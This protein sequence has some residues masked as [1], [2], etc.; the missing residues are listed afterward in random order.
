MA[1]K[2]V[3]AETIGTDGAG[4]EGAAASNFIRAIVEEDL[5]AG[6]RTEVITRFP[7]EPNGYP[8]IGHAKSICLN[9]GL[10][11][12]FGGTCHLRFDDTNPETEDIEYVEAIKRDVRW[13]GFDWKDKE[14][15]ASDYF[16][17]L[18]DW[19]VQLIRDGK[20]YVDDL[21]EDEIRA[22]R[23]TVTEPGRESP[24]R[25][26]SVAEN[27]DL[28]ERMRQGTFPD[29]SRVLRARIDMA[30][31][32]MKMRDP[33]M[34][35]IRHATHYRRGD[36]WC[37]YPMYDWAHGQSDAIE[38]ITHSICTLEFENNR[39]LYDWFLD[40][41]GVA[42]RP[43]QYE[44]ARLN[45]DY[46]I[47][48]KR[49]LL[50]LVEEGYVEGWDDPRMP[51]ISGM[52][53]RG[54]TPEAIRAF[55]ERIGVTKVDSRVDIGIF[56][57]AL[58]DDL[59]Y[60][61]PRVM[62]VLRPLKV[63]LTN[64]PDAQTEWLEAPYW[65]HDVPKEGARKVPFSRVLYIERDDFMERPPRRYHRLAPGREVRL[66]YGYFI[67]CREVVK[68]ASGEVVEL[69]CTYDPATR[70]GDAPDG[71][72]VKGTIHWVSAAHALPA[73]VRLYDRLFRRPNPDE[74]EEDFKAYLNPESVVVLKDSRIEP[75]VQ[76]D[77]PGTRY[78][79]ERQGYFWPDPEASAPGALVFNRI[80]TLRDSW[81]KIAGADAREATPAQ[82]AKPSAKAEAP[83]ATAKPS[84]DDILADLRAASAEQAQRFTRYADD[85]GLTLE[86]ARILAADPALSTFFED[87][88]AAQDDPKGVANW[89]VNELLGALDDRR[90]DLLPFGGAA[91]GALVGLIDDATISGRIAKDVLAEMIRQGGDPREIVR[92]RGLQQL[93][94]P[95][96]L[97]PI[98]DRLLAAHPDKVAQ[99]RAGKTGLAGFFVG[100]VMRETGG[101][102]NPKLVQDL[103]QQ[104]LG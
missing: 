63:V 54:V 25:N 46:T 27:L 68:D 66:R 87:A 74:G 80:V 45:L 58:R 82:E 75:S 86:E 65:P 29:G 56:E 53:R 39:E 23:G 89:V 78:Q 10:A 38:N 83:A 47:M 52:R 49:K 41:L 95:D 85:L 103:V 44:F 91:L 99:Y 102:A 77:P 57:H 40:N 51:T 20:A 13:L 11:E 70:G 24:Y 84:R 69:R 76:D 31:P 50:Q 55:A 59:N 4:R 104:K 1:T 93:T 43:Y 2:N 6:R 15:Y 73:E 100:Q 81:A 97:A 79:F 88:L 48:S 21:S 72:R 35:R 90:V 36:A 30:H 37:L 94:D 18:Y 26:R 33:L 7:P 71:R 8:H 42:P 61:A 96:A 62:C 14:F 9:F 67:T 60:R 32:N 19:A 28:F 16:E 3:N 22:Y 64:Y 5:K 17:Q 98:L 34:Y 92:R 101:K 12:D